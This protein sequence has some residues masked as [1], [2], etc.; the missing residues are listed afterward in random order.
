MSSGFGW[1]KDR[2]DRAGQTG[3]VG[4]YDAQEAQAIQARLQR[5]RQAHVLD[6]IAA[7]RRSQ[8]QKWGPVED[9]LHLV[10]NAL[11]V[12]M[13]EVGEVAKAQMEDG[14]LSD[15]LRTELVQV[16]AVAAAWVELIDLRREELSA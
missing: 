8:D 14:F 16:A 5:R 12:L 15:E 3:I 1:L 4:A 6:D 11:G 7:E 10:S 9:N 13:E 2:D